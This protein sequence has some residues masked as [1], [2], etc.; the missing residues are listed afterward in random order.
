MT[1][2]EKKAYILAHNKINLNTGFD[3]DILKNELSEI[4]DLDLS[5]FGFE[6]YD[7][8]DEIYDNES[9]TKKIKAPTYETKNERPFLSS[10]INKDYYN[11]LLNEINE[12][13]LPDDEKE[14]LRLAA[15]RHIIFNYELI[16]DYYAHSGIDM[17]NLM[18]NS[19]LVIID[20]DKALEKGFARLSDE[21]ISGFSCDDYEE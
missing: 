19:A 6:S 20:F 11:Q 8:E 14:F 5:K 17:Q 2:Q 15:S 16:A 10:V 4:T 1:E 18:E 12:S 21:L 9:Y 7:E 3:D 13:E